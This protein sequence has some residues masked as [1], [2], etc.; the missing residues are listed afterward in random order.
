[1]Q[2]SIYDPGFA[3]FGGGGSSS[4]VHPVALGAV[5]LITV[6]T[7][8][9][10]RKYVIVPLILGMLLIPYGQNLYIGGFHLFM[11]RLLI[12]IG[13]IR[14]V[15]S[16]PSSPEKFLPVGFNVLD[17][18]FLV[19]ACYRALATVVVYWQGAAVVGQVAFLWDALGGYFL[20]R[21]L[22]EDEETIFRVVK[23]FAVVGLIAAVG[24][25]YEQVKG[26]NAFAFLG[27][28]RAIPEI[29]EGRIRAQAFFGHA[30][31]AGA[32]GATTF[33]LFL[34]LWKR[35]KSWVF[36]L[37]GMI[38]S[39]VMAYAASTSTPIMAL[40]GGV[41]A[42]CLWP[43]RDN[44]RTLRWG[45]AITIVGLHLVMKSPVWFLIGRI[46]LSGGSTGYQRAVLIDN[47]MRHFSDWWLIGTRDYM[48]WGWDMWDQCNQYILEGENG[49]LIAFICFIAMF[50]V[51][52]RWIGNARK[53]VEGDKKKEWLYWILGAAFFSQTM[54][55]VG[56]D[57]FDQTKNVWYMLLV[58]VTVS[59]QFS[60]DPVALA[61]PVHGEGS[62]ERI[63]K[64]WQQLPAYRNVSASDEVRSAREWILDGRKKG[65]TAQNDLSKLPPIVR[66]R[67]GKLER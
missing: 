7:F 49:G 45:I 31:L 3:A 15:T 46:D 9:L 17:K 60:R 62:V 47:F 2:Q 18:V 22:V 5:G 54:A 59:T 57:Y 24:M 64:P 53:A 40:M 36:P 20:F 38:A 51:C 67:K 35:S 30:L 11:A 16:R 10:K 41:F 32:Y 42:L 63:R 66:L 26:Q 50:C 43:I 8:T 34:W 13:W 52:Y 23:A 4:L 33:C 65:N 1:M 29:R 55:F 21:C 28:V 37:A 19:W 27:G 56:V 44:M 6:L 58:I 25:I 61:A 12:V 48:N 39:M 14:V